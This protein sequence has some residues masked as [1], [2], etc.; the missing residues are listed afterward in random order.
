LRD[1]ARRAALGRAGQASLARDFQLE[2]NLDKL[3]TKFGLP[4][5]ADRVLRSA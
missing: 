4:R 5:H 1:P 2:P 3:A